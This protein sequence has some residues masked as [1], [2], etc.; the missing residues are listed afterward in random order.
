LRADIAQNSG[1][2]QDL[3]V[4]WGAIIRPASST[5]GRAAIAREMRI[6]ATESR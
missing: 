2:A 4:G 3:L 1:L 5:P 6:K